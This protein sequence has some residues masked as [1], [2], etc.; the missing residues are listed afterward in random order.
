MDFSQI[1]WTFLG[2]IA[3][4]KSLIFFLAM[5]L[6]LIT[7]RPLNLGMA[8]AFAIFVS[9]SNDFALGIPIVDAV[10]SKTHPNYNKYMY[11]I[12]PISLCFLNPIAFFFMELNEHWQSHKF[13]MSLNQREDGSCDTENSINSENTSAHASSKGMT[14][15]ESSSSLQFQG[16]VFEDDA[17]IA[18]EV[19]E[20][21]TKLS[22]VK[23]L[24]QTIWLTVKNPIVF[25]TFVGL[26]S[27]FIFD[28][29]IP[30]LIEPIITTLANSFSAI[31]LFY[32]GLTMVGKIRNLSFSTIIIIIVL[33]LSKGLIFPLINR[34]M[35]YLFQNSNSTKTQ[36]ATDTDNDDLSTFAFLYGTFP[37]APSLLIFISRYKYIQQD[38]FS[39]A[40]VFGTLASA[41]LMMVSGKY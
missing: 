15:S 27:N 16:F 38:L 18:T 39:S 30:S 28:R 11:L 31:A 13:K 17:E 40:I 41:P 5:I 25:M 35:V 29:K 1:E 22:K 10:Y 23:L 14:S 4:S 12:A 37:T 2:G 33:I 8:G 6:T 26:I 32:L 3:A 19:V 20:D 24:K 21:T 34:E 9:Q 7:I 36:P